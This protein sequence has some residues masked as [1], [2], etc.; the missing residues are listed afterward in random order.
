MV[1]V[2]VLVQR[3]LVGIAVALSAVGLL[4]QEPQVTLSQVP[5]TIRIGE[6]VE[7]QI[8]I[9]TSRKISGVTL[10]SVEGLVLRLGNPSQSGS[11][12]TVNGRRVFRAS[13]SYPIRLHALKLG[14]LTLPPIKVK[15]GGRDYSTEQRLIRV[16]QNVS[17]RDFGTFTV[18]PSKRRVYV[19]EP[20]R[21]D[22]ECAVATELK[23]AKGLTRQRQRY[24]KVEVESAW[25]TE[26]KFGRLIEA[27]STEPD[28]AEYMVLMGPCSRPKS[29]SSRIS[30]CFGFSGRSCPPIRGR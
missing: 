16:A 5:A 14:Q 22:F 1:E 12:F 13:V 4:A 7:V 27:S 11:E 3:C 18:V 9:R 17:A 6:V 23:L 10:P 2:I 24:N 29:A 8:E 20:V 26:P 28:G 19:H 30:A 21:F 25:L 15:I